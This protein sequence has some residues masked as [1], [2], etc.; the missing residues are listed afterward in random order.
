MS[1][2]NIYMHVYLWHNVLIVTAD[3]GQN[4]TPYG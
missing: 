3:I 1:V 2:L 4:S